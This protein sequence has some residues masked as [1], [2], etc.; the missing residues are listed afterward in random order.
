[1]EYPIVQAPAVLLGEFVDASRN[2]L[3]HRG[4]FVECGGLLIGSFD[5]V[6]CS[7]ENFIL[8]DQA[9]STPTSIVFSAEVFERAQAVTSTEGR[10]NGNRGKEILGTWHGH[11]PGHAQYSSTDEATL[12]QEQMRIRT[13]DP[14]LALSPRVHVIIPNYGL[15]VD[16]LR[17][18]TMQVRAEYVIGSLTYSLSQNFAFLEEE[19]LHSIRGGTSL[20][21]LVSRSQGGE[22]L[23][24]ERYH[25][26]QFLKG[27]E[28]KISIVGLWKHFPH[29]QV[30]NEFE[31]VFFE[32][33]YQ[34]TRMEKFIYARVLQGPAEK[35]PSVEWYDCRRSASE[36]SSITT[37]VELDMEVTGG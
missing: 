23:S 15:D 24:L 7:V 33:Y 14:G 1:M 3:E 17:V 22:P 26:K 27:E 13:D 36:L 4:G 20:G 30:V 34:K 5:G 10:G 31:K 21:L 16:D 29:S 6:R 37:F 8:D 12:F 25:P 32:N 28:G 2:F 19:I 11:P 18:F 9:I 35:C